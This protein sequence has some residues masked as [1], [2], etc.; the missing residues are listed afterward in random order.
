MQ[1]IIVA[2]AQRRHGNR[3]HMQPVIEVFTEVAPFH[4]AQDIPVG[5]ADKP[6][7]D[8]FRL[9]CAHFLEGA[10]L[11]KAQK[12][13]LQVHRHFTDLVQEKRAAIGRRGC[14]VTV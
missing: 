8:L 4:L 2:F 1:H 13:G 14:P 10:G 11:D 3:D 9:R 7:I 12:F 6:H 5:G